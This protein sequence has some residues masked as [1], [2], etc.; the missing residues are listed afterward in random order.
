MKKLAPHLPA[1]ACRVDTYYRLQNIKWLLLFAGLAFIA[2]I[3][4]TLIV[5][6]WVLPDN[7]ASPHIQIINLEH[8][9][10]QAAPEA[11]L[12]R[13]IKQRLLTIYDRRQKPGGEFYAFQAL[14]G[15]AAIISS[16]GWAVAYLSNYVSG[17]ERYWEIL[18][19]QA[20]EHKLEKVVYDKLDKMLYFKVNATGLRVV[21]FSQWPDLG[22]GSVLWSVGLDNW[23]QNFILS[24]A[25]TSLKALNPVW[26]PAYNFQLLTKA[27]PGE[28]LFD[29]QGQFVGLVLEANLVSHGWL[30]EKQT[31]ALLET[32]RL[33][34]SGL[35][36]QGY[37]VYNVGRDKRK[38]FYVDRVSA[39]SAVDS[40]L[41]GDVVLTINGKEAKAER[42]AENIWLAPPELLITVLRGEE[43]VDLTVRK[44][45]VL[46]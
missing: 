5:S 42:L 21:S 12:V 46:P 26:Q 29:N 38:G 33:V 44:E 36:W 35:P 25:K 34:F 16:D 18:D 2:G 23:Q 45:A 30:V 4:A 43:L 24:E 20:V 32:D 39:V 6:V 31:A 28:L 41:K 13:Q 3:S 14:V 22:Q 19:Y 15:Q 7:N 1:K 27:V 17:E 37:F 8:E 10:N 9:V 11:L 40:V